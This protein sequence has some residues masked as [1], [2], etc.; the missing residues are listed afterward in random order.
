MG[1]ADTRRYLGRRV[2]KQRT[3]WQ[4]VAQLKIKKEGPL[5]RPTAPASKKTG[6]PSKTARVIASLNVVADE[7]E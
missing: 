3:A 6:T 5:L 1:D 7:L 2:S 4:P